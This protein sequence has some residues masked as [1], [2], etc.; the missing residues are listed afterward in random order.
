MLSRGRVLVSKKPRPTFR[1]RDAF[2]TIACVVALATLSGCELAFYATIA[3][4]ENLPRIPTDTAPFPQESGPRADS[5]SEDARFVASRLV[6]CRE[7]DLRLT[8]RTRRRFTFVGCGQS[9]VIRCR[10]THEGEPTVCRRVVP[11]S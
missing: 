1:L 3:V 9:I 11:R 10:R 7:D 4:L 6:S 2:V 5:L 8:R